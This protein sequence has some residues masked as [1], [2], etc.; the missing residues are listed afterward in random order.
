[1]F[2]LLKPSVATCSSRSENLLSWPRCTSGSSSAGT[3]KKCS[4]GFLRRQYAKPIAGIANSK[5][6]PAATPPAM[7]PV[8]EELLPGC[9]GVGGLY[10]GG[11]EKGGAPGQ[12]FVVPGPHK[13]G[14][15]AKL[16]GVNKENEPVDG[17]SPDKLLFDRSRTWRAVIAVNDFGIGPERLL[18]LRRKNRSFSRFPNETGIGPVKLFKYK[19]KLTKFVRFPSSLG[20]VP[21]MLLL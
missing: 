5:A 17:T 16:I 7:A 10:G 3:S 13:L 12:G 2:L 8:L 4:C 20:I 14:L 6:A 18:L 9:T 19:S 1:M 15:F 21:L 11:G